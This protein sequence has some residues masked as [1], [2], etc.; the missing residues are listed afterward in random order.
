M[1]Q[2]AHADEEHKHCHWRSL[3]TWS[4][5]KA[6]ETYHYETYH[7]ETYH[8]ETGDETGDEKTYHYETG[9]RR[10]GQRQ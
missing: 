1:E 10:N 8:Y 6:Y 7:Y 5:S 3:R 4:S 9:G 2:S